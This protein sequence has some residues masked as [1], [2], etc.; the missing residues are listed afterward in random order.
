MAAALTTTDIVENKG[1]HVTARSE[2]TIFAIDYLQYETDGYLGLPTS[3]LGTDYVVPSWPQYNAQSELGIVAAYDGTTVT[4]TPSVGASGRT[5]GQ[6]YTVI[7]NQ[8]RTYELLTN[9][10]DFLPDDLTGTIITFG[11]AHRCFW[12]QRLRQYS[13]HG[14]VLQSH[15]GRDSAHESMGRVVRDFS[16]REPAEWRFLPD[17]RVDQ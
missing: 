2:V 17:S 11:Q 16:S 14:V 10:Q 12:R 6:P 7:L 4:I 15:R 13:D 9:Q 3:V 8:G 1:I 5:T